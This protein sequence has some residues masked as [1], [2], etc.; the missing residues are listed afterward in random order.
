MFRIKNGMI[1]SDL[2]KL[3]PQAVDLEEAVLGCCMVYPDALAMVVDILHEDSFYRETNKI[4]FKAIKRLYAKFDPVDTHTVAVELRR[5]EEI[6][7]A[8]GLYRL[9]TLT[10]G[11]TTSASVEKWARIVQE[12]AIKRQ[13]ISVGNEMVGAG[14]DET[15]DCFDILEAAEKSLM[16]IGEHGTKHD[17]VRIDRLIG[18]ATKEIE[19]ISQQGFTGI[20]SGFTELDRITGGWQKTDFVILAGRPGMGKTALALRVARNAAVDWKKPIA[21]FSLEM[22]EL[23]LTKRLLSGETEIEHEKFKHGNLDSNEW[24]QF[25]ES[26]GKLAESH[27]YVDDTPSA[28]LFDIR[29]KARRMKMRHGIEM[30][31]IDYLQLV[32]G[33]REKNG[34]REQE[35][36]SIAR[37]MKALAKELDVPVIALSQLSRECE[38]RAD[39][40]PLL[41]DLRESGAIEQDADM[42]VFL[43]RPEYYKISEWQ[44]GSPTNGQAEVIIAKHRNGALGEARIKFVPEFVQFRELDYLPNIESEHEYRF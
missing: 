3:P 37:G 8:G 14:F 35:I 16:Q 44:D 34:N 9:T 31:L 5:T 42:V 6:E 43:Y 33:E 20:P 26:I 7:S 24:R 39:K 19:S 41:S 27:I 28:T 18:D 22:S 11:I 4:V 1:E 40:R 23:Q 13:V 32:R 2:G 29:A 36:S 30:I 10:N 25:N 15:K 38:K 17:F 21:I 12:M